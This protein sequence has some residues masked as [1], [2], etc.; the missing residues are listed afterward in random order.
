MRE[1]LIIFFLICLSLNVS[2]Q[3]L[4]YL[5]YDFSPN[6]DTIFSDN[7]NE[8]LIFDFDNDDEKKYYLLLKRKVKKVFPYALKAKEILTE[9]EESLV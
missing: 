2:S 6:G 3:N 1:S 9:I 7:L 8:I 5:D 4:K